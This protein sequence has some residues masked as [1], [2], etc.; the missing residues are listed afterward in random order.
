MWNLAAV[1]LVVAIIVFCI[2]VQFFICWVEPFFKKARGDFKR[3]T[4]FRAKTLQ[5]EWVYG[6]LQQNF[7]IIRKCVWIRQLGFLNCVDP[8]RD[9]FGRI[10]VRPDTIGQITGQKDINQKD[11]FES[12][13]LRLKNK[14]LTT[15]GIVRFGEYGDGHF[16]WFI[17]PT[18]K[19]DIPQQ[20][21]FWTNGK[22][23][24]CEVI[25][26]EFDNPDYCHGGPIMA[27]VI[28][29]TMIR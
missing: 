28:T 14:D 26:N 23:G 18:E 13:I 1:K 8:R 7:G 20:L 4:L 5:D 25:G 3:R 9:V 21:L 15:T 24:S 16:G 11:I 10:L 27:T 12:D 19:I 2:A 17:Q 29:K 22:E 6:V